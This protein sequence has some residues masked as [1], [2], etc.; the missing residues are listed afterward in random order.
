MG[1]DPEE[2][3]IQVVGSIEWSSDEIRQMLLDPGK[4]L[5][6]CATVLNRHPQRLVKVVCG[7]MR[8]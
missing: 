1:V 6:N 2:L 5:S 4:V 7:P 8:A 3:I